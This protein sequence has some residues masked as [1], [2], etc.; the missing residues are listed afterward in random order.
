M[1]KFFLMLSLS[2]I[3]HL[4]AQQKPIFEDKFP[5]AV[6][7]LNFGTFHMGYTPDANSV[8]FDEHNKKNQEDV[9]KVAKMLANFKPTVI[10]VED[11]PEN[12]AIL[13]KA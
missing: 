1:N 5:D 7:V 8:D 13:Q 11:L 6:Q 2:I 3:S 12:N 10:I 9:H 4:Q